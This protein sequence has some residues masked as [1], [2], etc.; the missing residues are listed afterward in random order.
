[1]KPD[2]DPKSFRDNPFFEGLDNRQRDD[3]L[4]VGV[5]NRYSDGDTVFLEGDAGEAMYLVLSGEVEIQVRNKD[6]LQEVFGMLKAGDVFGEGALLAGESRTA[7]VLS[8]RD[9]YLI[10]FSRSSVE[11]M[12]ESHPQAAARF[13]FQ[14]LG[15]VFNRLRFTTQRLSRR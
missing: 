4:G 2:I 11:K 6:G 13:L 10:A 12:I 14:L 8:V 9:S 5:V 7:T 3:I 15:K 1:M